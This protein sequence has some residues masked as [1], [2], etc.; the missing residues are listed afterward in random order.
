MRL[1]IILAL[2]LI[3][4]VFPWALAVYGATILAYGLWYVFSS[5]FA[6][7]LLIFAYWYSHKSSERIA[8]RRAKQENN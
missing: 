6:T 2:L 7:G 4:A 5:L 8:R 1:A 3:V